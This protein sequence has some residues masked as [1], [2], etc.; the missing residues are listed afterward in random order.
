[1]YAAIIVANNASANRAN[2]G[3]RFVPSSLSVDAEAGGAVR[4]D[5]RGFR[6]V[7]RY[8]SMERRISRRR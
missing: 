6:R 1:M 3:S 5:R 2:F 7:G 8:P 4:Y